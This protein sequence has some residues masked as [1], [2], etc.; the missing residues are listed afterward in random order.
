M[1]GIL[2]KEW[3]DYICVI[4]VS[5]REGGQVEEA[6][7]KK[8]EARKLFHQ[9]MAGITHTRNTESPKEGIG[10]KSISSRINRN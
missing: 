10:W 2:T 1:E 9:F 8:N 5:N 7:K 6:K 4:P 3:H